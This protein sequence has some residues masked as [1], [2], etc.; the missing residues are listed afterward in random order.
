MASGNATMPTIRP[1]MM[2]GLTCERVHK[3][4]ALVSSSAIMIYES[5]QRPRRLPGSIAQGRRAAGATGA[6]F[7][8]ISALLADGHLRAYARPT[9]AKRFIE[10]DE[11][12]GGVP[13]ALGKRVVGRIQR[14]IDHAGGSPAPN[15]TI[16]GNSPMVVG[17]ERT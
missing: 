14:M 5:K 12:Q 10:R 17:F 8:S 4:A 13:F 2:L 9:A 1:A 3:P 15:A 7:G 16:A 6:H 11:R